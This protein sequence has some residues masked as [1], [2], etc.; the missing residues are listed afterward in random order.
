ME[1]MLEI[2]GRTEEVAIQAGL[3]KLGLERDDVSVQVINRAKTGLLG[4]GAK[5]A[6][7]CLRYQVP[8][9]PK[10]TKKPEPSPKTMEKTKEIPKNQEKT[11]GIKPEPP[12]KPEKPVKTK[13][14][15]PMKPEPQS[16]PPEQKAEKPKPQEGNKPDYRLNNQEITQ[17]KEKIHSYLE[18]LLV[19]LHVQAEPEVSFDG[20]EFLVKFKGDDL[21]ALI[22]RR[23][24]TLDAIQQLTTYS[25]RRLSTKRFK[26]YV[27]AENFRDKRVATLKKLAVKVAGQVQK[28]G[29]NVTLEPMNAYERHIIHVA[30]EHIPQVT[31][32]SVGNDPNRKIVVAKAKNKPQ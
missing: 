8:D 27:D 21:G 24:E 12:V 11:E 31:T 29:K 7:V 2:T 16:K 19:H 28:T 14:P 26:I 4:F 23:G 17:L 13:P 22:G 18:G 20:K 30:L 9:P 5:P 1:K 15:E 3:E 6:K 25:M 10:E 32:Y